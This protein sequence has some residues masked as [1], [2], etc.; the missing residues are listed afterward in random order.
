[1]MIR[2]RCDSRRRFVSSNKLGGVMIWEFGQDNAR[3]SLLEA[4]NAGLKEP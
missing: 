3:S 4:V 2:S 1:M